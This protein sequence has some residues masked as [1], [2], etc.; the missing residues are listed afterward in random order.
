MIYEIIPDEDVKYYDSYT[1]AVI[2][3]GGSS[4]P[5]SCVTDVTC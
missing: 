1:A 2:A 3:N 5:Y 4:T